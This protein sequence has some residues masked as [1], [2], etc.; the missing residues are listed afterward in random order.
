VNPYESGPR[1]A[2]NA[3]TAP[4]SVFQ[5]HHTAGSRGAEPHLAD[6]A[7]AALR[8][9]QERVA[10]RQR[11]RVEADLTELQREI[12]ADDNLAREAWRSRSADMI[13]Q[14]QLAGRVTRADLLRLARVVIY[15]AEP[16]GLEPSGGGPW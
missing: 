3:G 7:Y 11:R 13:R 15:L 6:P 8:Q 10:R 12:R 2:G 14:N 5:Q 4:S 1:G 16:A 9:E